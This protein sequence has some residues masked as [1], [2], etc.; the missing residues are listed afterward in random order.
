MV[1]FITGYIHHETPSGAEKT[2]LSHSA[3]Y[4][5]PGHNP[6]GLPA[7]SSEVLSDEIAV[8]MPSAVCYHLHTPYP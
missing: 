5:V 3:F 2:V 1:K 8:P 6:M 7:S 4:I